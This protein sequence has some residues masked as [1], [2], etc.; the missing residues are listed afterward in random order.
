MHVTVC[1]KKEREREHRMTYPTGLSTRKEALMTQLLLK[2]KHNSKQRVSRGGDKFNADD[3]QQISLILQET[4]MGR[5]NPFKNFL[6]S[7]NLIRL[8]MTTPFVL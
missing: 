7:T 6:N 4:E 3:Q 5:G 2:T 1:Q 8:Q